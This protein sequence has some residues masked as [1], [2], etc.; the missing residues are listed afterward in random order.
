MGSVLACLYDK[1]WEELV[2]EKIIVPLG[3][4]D[5]T[6]VLN[7]L[8]YTK[9][10]PEA[11]A[12]KEYLEIPGLIASSM[13]ITNVTD[14]V[15]ELEQPSGFRW[16]FRTLTWKND[17]RVMHQMHDVHLELMGILADAQSE[18]KTGS[19]IQPMPLIF[20]EHSVEKLW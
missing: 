20:S 19:M 18:W 14:L 8:E 2:H 12:F 13:R 17:A 1:S 15:K 10:E 7:V 16:T 5:T 11:A 9:P 3:L 4:H 6:V